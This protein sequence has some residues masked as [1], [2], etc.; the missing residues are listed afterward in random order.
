[1]SNGLRNVIVIISA[2]TLVGC[3]VGKASRWSHFHGDTASR[4]FQPVESGFAL[5]SSWVSNPYRITS[6]SPVIGVD[7]QA[8]EVIYIG[9][10]NGKLIAIR[11]E[12]GTQKWQRALGPDPSKS[13]IVGSASVSDKGDIYVISNHEADDGRILSTLH[14]VDQFSNPQWSYSFPDNGYTTGSPKVTSSP[15]GTH[16]FV[17][18]SV[19]MTDDIQG[20]LFVLRDNGKRAQLLAR[21]SLGVCRFDAS[22]GRPGL[23][24]ILRAEKDTWNMVGIFPPESKEGVYVLPDSYVDP[25]VAVVSGEG[26]TLIAIADSLCSIG[27]FEWDGTQLSV[28][29]RQEHDFDKHSSAAILPDG[30]MVFGGEDGKVLAYDVKTGVK[31]WEYDAGQPVFA[32]PAA[33][34]KQQVFVVSKDNLQVL[35]TADGTV[36]RDGKVAEKLPLLGT[37]YSS[38]AVTFNRVYVSS[39]EMLTATHDLKA[40]S[41]DTN[42]HGNGLSSIAIGRDGAVYAVAEDGTLR[43]YAG[44]Q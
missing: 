21:K 41:H 19:G 1:M 6:S 28:L 29:W 18:V 25:T 10:A 5:S 37:T 36:L 32:T 40:R 9:T 16:I 12:D 34:V 23:E 38:P 42:F 13:R 35:N 4:G 11:S 2:V 14:K 39:L 30:M 20:E 44:K 43:K 7:Y 3:T 26:K 8:R 17:Y 31:M 27:V 22:G 33:S 15:S 24:D